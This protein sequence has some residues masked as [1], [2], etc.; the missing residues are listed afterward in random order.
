VEVRGKVGL[1]VGGW[2]SRLGVGVKVGVKARARVGARAGVRV[3]V[4]PRPLRVLGYPSPH[5]PR[6]C[7]LRVCTCAFL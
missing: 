3:W 1:K 6:T 7:T 5:S 2:G 4:R